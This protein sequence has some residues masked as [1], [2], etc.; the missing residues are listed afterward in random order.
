LKKRRQMVAGISPT[1]VPG[2]EVRFHAR[3]NQDVRKSASASRVSTCCTGAAAENEYCL[4]DAGPRTLMPPFATVRSAIVPTTCAA[5]GAAPAGRTL[6]TLALAAGANA[7]G[8]T[9]RTGALGGAGA[10]DGRIV[11]SERF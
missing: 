1:A 2:H 5:A 4:P 11:K 7:A 9:L 10:A 6:R 3:R 8:R